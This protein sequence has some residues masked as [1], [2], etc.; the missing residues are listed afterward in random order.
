MDDD[1]KKEQWAVV[2]DGRFLTVHGS[3]KYVFKWDVAEVVQQVCGGV[4]V[5]IIPMTPL[6]EVCP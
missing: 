4:I 6:V 3:E 5:K 2:K 1:K